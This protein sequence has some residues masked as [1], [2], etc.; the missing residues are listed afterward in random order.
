ML[1]F[2]KVSNLLKFSFFFFIVDVIIDAH[3]ET[4]E[5]VWRQNKFKNPTM[6]Q[7]SSR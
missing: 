1:S 2:E 7:I 5:D 6:I 4:S 3:I